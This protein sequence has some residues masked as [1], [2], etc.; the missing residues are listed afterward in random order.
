MSAPEF[1]PADPR[2]EVDLVI[3]EVW[4]EP[5]PMNVG[6]MLT[7]Y[8]LEDADGTHLG[9]FHTPAK[10]RLSTALLDYVRKNRGK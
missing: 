8:R 3:S 7:K 2:A 6:W 5:D 4:Q 9:T 1:R 10:S